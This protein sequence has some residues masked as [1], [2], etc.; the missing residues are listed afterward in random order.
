MALLAGCG[1]L[2]TALR[3]IKLIMQVC[4]AKLFTGRHITHK[5][6]ARPAD[7]ERAFIP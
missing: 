4:V 2:L 7:A 1:A 6:K 3:Q 5:E